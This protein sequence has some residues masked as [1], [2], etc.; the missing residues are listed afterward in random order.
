MINVNCTIIVGLS[1]FIT[2]IKTLVYRSLRIINKMDRLLRLGAAMPGRGGHSF[3]IFLQIIY[4][5]FLEQDLIIRVP[6]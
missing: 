3:F 2:N 1:L 4:C 5:L 6:L